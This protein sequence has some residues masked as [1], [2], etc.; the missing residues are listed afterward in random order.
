MMGAE[1][2]ASEARS[3]GEDW[4]WL[5]EHSRN[6]ASE[7]RLAGREAGKK[8]GTAEEARDHCFGVHEGRGHK[9]PLK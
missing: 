9:A 5:C 3:Q 7:P 8:S 1:A 2:L 4:G 6:G